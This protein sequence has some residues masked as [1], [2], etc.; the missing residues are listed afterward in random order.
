MAFPRILTIMGQISLRLLVAVREVSSMIWNFL[1]IVWII[2]FSNVVDAQRPLVRGGKKRDGEDGPRLGPPGEGEERIRRAPKMSPKLKPRPPPLMVSPPPPPSGDAPNLYQVCPQLNAPGLVGAGRFRYMEV[3]INPPY[4]IVLYP[5]GEVVSDYTV[6]DGSWDLEL[7]TALSPHLVQYPGQVIVNAGGNIGTLAIFY[8][9]S[10]YE[11]FTM[12]PHPQNFMLMNC[13]A[14][15]NNLV[16]TKK[17][18]LF[19]TAL[20]EVQDGSVC[21]TNIKRSNMGAMGINPREQGCPH[22]A[23][24]ILLPKFIEDRASVF[25]NRFLLLLLD[26]EAYEPVVLKTMQGILANKQLRPRFIVL[27]TGCDRWKFVN[28]LQNCTYVTDMILSHNYAVIWPPA[29]VENFMDFLVKNKE[30]RSR[31]D[32]VLFAVH[33]A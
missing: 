7:I 20:G 6:K 5:P 23:P 8:A 25:S 9:K 3:R 22:K 17:I 4:H 32:N 13:S 30:P 19:E 2:A 18:H 28:R 21:L 24:S 14:H 11:V 16:A 12:E 26:L 27:E 1:C 10:G 33:D 15:V 31:D 29:A